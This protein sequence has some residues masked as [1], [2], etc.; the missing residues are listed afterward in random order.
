MG[1]SDEVLRNIYNSTTNTIGVSGTVYSGG[2]A[3]QLTTTQ[4]LSAGALSYTTALTSNF[5]VKG[6]YFSFTGAVTQ[7]I[8][9]V[10][11]GVTIFA[12]TITAGTTAYVEG[13]FTILGS[14]SK[15]LT[16]SCTNNTNPAITVTLTIDCEV[17]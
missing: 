2:T 4:D 3:Q 15:N 17:I 16:V 14:L 12:N 11:N 6:V 5:V 10:Y 9:L 8:A 7:D 1:M 13:D